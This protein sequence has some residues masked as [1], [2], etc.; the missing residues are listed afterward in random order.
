MAGFSALTTDRMY[1]F[2]MKLTSMVG[3]SFPPSVMITVNQLNNGKRVQGNSTNVFLDIAMVPNLIANIN[4]PQSYPEVQCKSKN[5]PSRISRKDQS[6][7]FLATGNG[8]I[9]LAFD[10]NVFNNMVT[11]L[12]AAYGFSGV[13]KDVLDGVFEGVANL[14]QQAGFQNVKP[15]IINNRQQGNGMGQQQQMQQPQQ[16]QMMPNMSMPGGMPGM[17]PMGQQQNNMQPPTNNGLPGAATASMPMPGGLP[18]MP[19]MQQP[20]PQQQPPTNNGMPGMP[21]MPTGTLPTSVPTDAAS[22]QNMLSGLM[23]GMNQ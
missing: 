2:E 19:G 11:Y 8:V 10:P 12:N 6:N 17:P 15:Y 22:M 3:S 4:N 14:L 23:G 13:L 1:L 7:M 9:C 5:S 18:G 21:G 16:Q 20:Q